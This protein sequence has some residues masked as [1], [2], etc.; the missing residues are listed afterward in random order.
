VAGPVILKAYA[1][2]GALGLFSTSVMAA[3]E[4]AG[5]RH[6]AIPVQARTMAVEAG[7]TLTAQHA[8]DA[9]SEDELLASL[10]IVAT[11]PTAGGQWLIYV[12]GNTSPRENGVAA[13][14]L[15]A[16][17]DAGTALD[18]D[19]HG[20][21]Q[22][23]ALHYLWYLGN[24]ALVVGLIDPAGP[25][26]NSN[27]ANDETQQFL[28][29]TLVNNPT[30]AF[31]SYTLGMVYFYKPDRNAPDVT[32]L[33]T[34]SNGLADNP[35]RS[36]SELVDVSAH[37]K[38]VFA[39]AELVWNHSEQIWRWGV[40]LQTAENPY[41]DGSGTTANNYGTYLNTDHR[42][43]Q[44]A[45]N[46]RL[47][48]ANASVSLAAGFI[49]IAAERDFGKGHAGIGITRTF[50][51]SYAGAGTGDRDQF[52]I[53]YRYNPADNFSITPSL[54]KIRNSSFG[55]IGS[56]IDTDVSVFSLRCSYVF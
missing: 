30:I 29:S 41:V 52:E 10:D 31:L 18:R 34:S 26:D 54:Q 15:E 53:Y 7:T 17:A 24:N 20:R 49:G 45:M 39:A 14:F 13:L 46:L 55:F 56:S 8:T 9:R 19:G 42:L 27:I 28:A 35:N 33:L 2:L 1:Y 23:S 37:G 6:G 25:L 48:L 36:Y 32:L 40:W 38:G 11:I 12:E 51:S 21:L 44:Y 43:G 4:P 22:V 16:N 47:G 50:V 5:A 3:E